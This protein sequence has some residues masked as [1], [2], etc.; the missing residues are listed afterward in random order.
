MPPLRR[1][2]KEEIGKDELKEREIVNKGGKNKNNKLKDEIE[3]RLNLIEKSMVNTQNNSLIELI[4]KIEILNAP[5]EI[6]RKRDIIVLNTTRLS[7]NEKTDKYVRNTICH[8]CKKYGHTKKQCDR[9]NKIVKK[10]SK[11]EFEK[12]II[13]ELIK[14]FDIN[15][16][17]IDQVKEKK[18]L[19]STNPIKVNKRKR[20]KKDIIMKLLDNL[21]NHLRD[22]TDYL[23][24]LKDSIDIPTACVMCKKYGHHVTDCQKKKKEK[25]RN[26][27]DR[28]DI[29]LVTLQDLMTE[30]KMVKQEIKEDNSIDINEQNIAEIIKL[31]ELS[32][33]I[34]ELPLLEKD[35]D[36]TKQKIL[37]LI[38]RVI[39]Q[40]WHTEITLVINKEFSLTEIALIDS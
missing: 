39:F 21:P 17:E 10:I 27:Q 23:L 1:R 3:K 16:K 30:A 40:K 9:H 19:K 32:K 22:R 6:D 20:N 37:S 14:M 38:N 33:P 18:E 5:L 28:I 25:T 4:R 26:K 24:K 35:N 2:L 34:T 11:L 12:D 31:K 8:K 29:K 7:D 13:N 36:N 15:P